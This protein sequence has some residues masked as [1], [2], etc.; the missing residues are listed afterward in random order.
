MNRLLILSLL[1]APLTLPA[2]DSTAKAP[3][4]DRT[5]LEKLHLQ[6]VHAS[7]GGGAQPYMGN[8]SEPGPTSEFRLGFTPQ[9]WPQ[10]TIALTASAVMRGDTTGYLAPGSTYHPTMMAT[11][12]G[13]ELQRRWRGSELLHP[14]VAVS[15]G[16]L[17]NSYNYFKFPR[18]GGQE[19]HQDELTSTA[20]GTIE[21][22][23]ELNVAGWLRTT[24]TVGYRKA[25]SARISLGPG[26][27]S[28]VL[29]TILV[30]MGKF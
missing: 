18:T 29:S 12:V 27:N 15:A 24:L 5:L 3:P 6:G 1:I 13:V 2:Q 28:G 11:T 23:G 4:K 30:E 26:T 9:R 19:F 20:Y 17:D 10:W 8:P 25:G 7:L 22:G 16:Q 21:A 14:L